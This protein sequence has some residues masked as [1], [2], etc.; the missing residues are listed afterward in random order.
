M[1]QYKPFQSK[2]GNCVTAARQTLTLFVGVRIPIPQPKNPRSSE[3]GFFYPSRRL[4]ISLTREV[5]RISSRAARRPCISSRASVH[6]LRLDDIQHFVLMICNSYGID[7]MHAFGVI[8]HGGLEISTIL[9]YTNSR[10]A[11]GLWK[12]LKELILM[13]AGY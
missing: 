6:F 5:R 12:H 4:G 13:K 9:C 7:D 8:W 10:K 11:V 1:L 2:L 3:R